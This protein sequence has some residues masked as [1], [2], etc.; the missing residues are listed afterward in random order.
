MVAKKFHTIQN[1]TPI[2]PLKINQNSAKMID[3][4]Q[5]EDRNEGGGS[6][7]ITGLDADETYQ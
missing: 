1:D 2:G 3:Q 5:E 7:M 6:M 4:T